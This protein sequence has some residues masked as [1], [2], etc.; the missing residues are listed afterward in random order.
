MQ[1]PSC[2]IKR[3]RVPA[4]PHSA[5]P[6]YLVSQRASDVMG[7]QFQAMQQNASLSFLPCVI[8][9]VV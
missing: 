9:S 6:V 8:S 4:P 2:V 5:T 3:R 1:K 7:I